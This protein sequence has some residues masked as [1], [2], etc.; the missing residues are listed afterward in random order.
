MEHAQRLAQTDDIYGGLNFQHLD[1][2]KDSNT[3]NNNNNNNDNN[4][5]DN[6]DNDNNKP[7]ASS[8]AALL[9]L[10]HLPLYQDL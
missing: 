9:R 7:K 6:N 3:N 2:G 10:S 4:D 8:C 5:N 1:R